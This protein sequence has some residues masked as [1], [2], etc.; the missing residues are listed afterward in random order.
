MT[1]TFVKTPMTKEVLDFKGNFLTFVTF[2]KTAMTKE[3]VD[4]KRK[5]RLSSEKIAPK[6]PLR[7]SPQKIGGGSLWCQKVQKYK[8]IYY[9][10]YY[11]LYILIYRLTEYSLTSVMTFVIA[12]DES[13]ETFLQYFSF[14]PQRLST[15]Q[16]L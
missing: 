11:Y 8:F 4:F 16:V 2:D 15:T 1:R 5:N 6:N 10:Y 3:V 7:K 9:F 12:H 14:F 13:D